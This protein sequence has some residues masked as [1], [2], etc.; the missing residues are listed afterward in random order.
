MNTTRIMLAASTALALLGCSSMG[1]VQMGNDSTMTEATAKQLAGDVPL[2]QGAVIKQQDT[3]VM[4][5]GNTWMG[6]L[7]LTVPGEAQPAFAWFRDNLPAAGWTLTSSSFSKLSLLTFTKAE[8]VATVQMQGSNFGG[9]E[10]LITVAPAVR[11][12]SRP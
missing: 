7:S 4:G 10:V 1:N 3:L 8:R 9:N 11:P 5:S 6:R 12:A 2:P